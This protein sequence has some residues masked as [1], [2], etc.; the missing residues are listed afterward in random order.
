MYKVYVINVD[1]ATI[2]INISRREVVYLESVFLWTNSI[3]TELNNSFFL[4]HRAISRA[5]SPVQAY[6]HGEMG[7]LNA[8]A[9]ATARRMKPVLINITSKIKTCFKI[10]EYSI[11]DST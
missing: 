1:G 7:T 2:E 6:S 9:P 4:L 8:T 11:D 10:Y 5:P 3:F